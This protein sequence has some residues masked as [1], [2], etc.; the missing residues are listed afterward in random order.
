M[1][2]LQIYPIADMPFNGICLKDC[3]HQ[4]CF[5]PYE[6]RPCIR[7]S[8]VLH[9]ILHGR[10]SFCSEGQSWTL[11]EGDGFLIVPDKVVTYQADR[12]EPWEY[13]FISFDG[14]DAPCLMQ[15][16]GLNAESPVY[17]PAQ[18]QMAQTV[19]LKILSMVQGRAS[20]LALHGAFMELLDTMLPH[21]ADRQHTGNEY[22][23]ASIAFID[24]SYAY[25]MTIGDIARRIGVDR[26]YLFRLFKKETGMSPQEYLRNYR[27]KKAQALLRTT[28]LTLD[29]VAGSTGLG[30]ASHLSKLFREAYGCSPGAYRQA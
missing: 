26:T 19:L 30:D 14:T 10:G 16:C 11:K 2:E 29:M 1:Y 6:T 4:R 27:L 20:S 7:P 15:A 21:S 5:G 28:T 9:L 18:V 8:Y 12:D 23:N 17:R 13:A 24:Q 22:L 3:G 25:P